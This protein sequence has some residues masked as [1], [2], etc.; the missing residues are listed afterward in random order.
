MELVLPGFCSYLK[1][2][3][4]TVSQ[5]AR[6]LRQTDITLT[7][8]FTSRL[9]LLTPTELTRISFTEKSAQVCVSLEAGHPKGSGF[10]FVVEILKQMPC[11]VLR[12]GLPML[13][14]V[15][16][17]DCLAC[18]GTRGVLHVSGA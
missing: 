4:F 10:Q 9:S 18:R 8:I 5:A 11:G 12:A 15:K 14:N 17:W 13:C 7:A 3:V 1:I 2:L 16:P 6:K